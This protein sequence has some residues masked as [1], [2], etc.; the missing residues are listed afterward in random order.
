MILTR[1]ENGFSLTVD[2]TQRVDA[3]E[4]ARDVWVLVYAS[5]WSAEIRDVVSVHGNLR[6]AYRR[7]STLLREYDVT[8]EIGGL[9]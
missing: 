9:T 8:R 7:A 1:V 2:S 3:L 5:P 6:A 4:L